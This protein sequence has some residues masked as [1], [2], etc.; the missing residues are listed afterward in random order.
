MASAGGFRQEKENAGEFSATLGTA[1]THFEMSK[2]RRTAAPFPATRPRG[3]SALKRA[4]LVSRE[5]RSERFDSRNRRRSQV[6]PIAH[7]DDTAGSGQWTLHVVVD[8][9]EQEPAL[10]L[11]EE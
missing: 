8:L 3:V 1:P 7:R 10:Q 5:S 2:A 6:V 11:D 9:A 4:L